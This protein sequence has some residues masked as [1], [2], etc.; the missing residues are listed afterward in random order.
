MSN[1]IELNEHQ[2]EDVVGGALKWLQSG[3]VYP[4]NNPDCKYGY[5]DYYKCAA[6]LVANWNTIQD[7]SCLEAMEKAGLVYKL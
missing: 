2:V 4:K 1:R 3:V 5:T 7:E 6:W